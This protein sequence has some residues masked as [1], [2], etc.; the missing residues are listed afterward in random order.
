MIESYRIPDKKEIP[1]N[2]EIIIN[3]HLP[4]PGFLTSSFKLILKHL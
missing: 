2:I 4:E 3:H 1:P